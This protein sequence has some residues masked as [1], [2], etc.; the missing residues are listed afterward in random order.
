MNVIFI[1]NDT[2]RRDH[3][4][5]YGNPWIHTPNLDRFA[6]RAAVF[7]QFYAASYPTVPNRW[8]L[9]TGRF[10]FPIRGW[11]PLGPEDVTW[12]QILSANGV[13]TQMIWDTPMLGM[14]DYNYTRGFRGLTF[15]HGQKGD[16]WITNPS[17]EIQLL[18]QPHK[19]RNISSL[20]GYLSNHFNRQFER[21]F[22]VG[23]AISTAMDWL[24]TNY[25]QESFF[26]WVDMWDPHEPFDCPWYDYARYA[27]PD[28][29][30][31]R[32]LYPEYG[33]PTYMTEVEREHL[34]ALYAGNVTLTDRWIG[35]FLDLA[36][37]LGL[38]K[39]TLII[40]AS[41]HGHLFGDH[42]LQGKP[43]AELGKLYEVTIRIPLLV[44]HPEGLGAGKR[45]GGFVQ[46]PDILPS[47][48]DFL[49]IS[50]PSQLQGTSFWPLVAGSQEKI[51]DYAFSSRF[52]PTAGTATYASVE[53]A[54]F[55]GWVGS[56]RNV[57][58]STVTD[59]EWA[60]LCA[61]QGMPSELYNLK[62]DPDQEHNVIDA[63]PDVAEKMRNAWITFLENQGASET[64]IRPFQD[65]NVEVH[66]PTSGRLYAFRDDQGQWVAFATEREARRAAY[67]DDAPGSHRQV[68]AV[69]FGA[70]LDDNPKNLI[71]LYGQYYWAQDLV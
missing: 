29:A 21:E 67:R 65:A 20:Q 24:E 40:W 12:G 42:D 37:R 17:F 59:D 48:L 8:D 43:G 26:L 3:L 36:E 55:D 33:R 61:P 58:P 28:Y 2:F 6:Q 32:M 11:Q 46:P 41:D 23:R 45:I 35:A 31:D 10:G 44:Y 52:P 19:I 53:G 25:N 64:R 30:G 57:E 47:I 5:C 63:H 62:T 70:L 1:M 49:D 34:R 66:T 15:V 39:N 68:E 51:H 13:H 18:A 50:V 9:T 69:T 54:T 38:F 22:C 7:E 60:F 71:H 27:N 56:D 14:H 16:P 4:G